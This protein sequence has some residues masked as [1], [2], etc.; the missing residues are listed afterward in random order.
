MSESETVSFLGKSY[1]LVDVLVDQKR[2]RDERDYTGG[3]TGGDAP[4]F[5]LKLIV[6]G[7]EAG[8]TT[9]AE[10][11]VPILRDIYGGVEASPQKAADGL[12]RYLLQQFNAFA[13]MLSD[14]EDWMTQLKQLMYDVAVLPPMGADMED[15]ATKRG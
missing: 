2:V 15:V 4:F 3:A 9:T 8:L 1:P 12:A 6:G 5:L 7:Y 14:R 11:T 13:C 10:D